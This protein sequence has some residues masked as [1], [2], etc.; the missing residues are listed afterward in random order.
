MGALHRT[1]ASTEMPP[2]DAWARVCREISEVAAQEPEQARL[3]GLSRAGALL[4]FHARHSRNLA[5]RE[6]LED[7]GVDPTAA[8]QAPVTWSRVP[9]ID[10]QWLA[11]AGYDRRPACP[12][13]V[14]VVSTSGSTATQVL[15]PVTAECANRGLGDNFLRALAMSG[16]G[17]Q[18]RHWGIEHRPPGQLGVTGSSISMTWLT[19]HCGSNALV[20]T[21]TEPLDEQLRRAVA[22]GPDTISGSPGFLLQIAR[23][24][25]DL[26]PV[27]LLYGGAALTGTEAG[28]LRARFPEARLVA[29]YPT[30]DAGA[31]GAAPA[32][33][34][35]YRTFTETHL[36]EV[37][38][39]DGGPVAVGS[40]GDVVVTQFDARAAPII[41]YRAGDRATYLGWERGRLLLAEIER[42]A[43]AAIGS[44]LVP[45]SDL[46]T[47]MP[48]LAARDP[49]IVAVQLVRAYSPGARREQPIVRVIGRA[50]GGAE[51]IAAARSLLDDFPQIASEV[52]SG[53]LAPVL[54]EFRDPPATLAGHWKIPLYVDERERTV[55][56]SGQCLSGL[57]W[58]RA[59]TCKIM[60]P[61]WLSSAASGCVTSTRA[62]SLSSRRCACRAGRPGHAR[63]SSPIIRRASPGCGR[64]TPG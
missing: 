59:P 7:A 16:V 44:T 36:I 26:S 12:G 41:R 21:A 29:F 24:E 49:S 33:E 43:E 52:A 6:L 25:A 35:A 22:F 63:R 31:F 13:P 64:T 42:T 45:Y 9:V 34:G 56:G 18:Q 20:T 39:D 19:R 53:E 30:T 58:Q 32:G 54:V 3:S 10:K 23:A 57:L 48:R 4:R 40:R 15:V 51:L 17:P 61:G 28:R 14:L 27:L 11:R 60:P 5:Y 37:L 8:S 47:W 38:G 2:G 1:R 50:A 46:R 55:P 62:R